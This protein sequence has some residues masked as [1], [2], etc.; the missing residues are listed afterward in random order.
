MPTFAS[1]PGRKLFG[2]VRGLV[3]AVGVLALSTGIAAAA[4]SISG[5][6]HDGVPA[7]TKK[8]PGDTVTYTTLRWFRF[9]LK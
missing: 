3:I 4:P 9:N 6:K 1:N 7:G 2:V 8:N 5:T